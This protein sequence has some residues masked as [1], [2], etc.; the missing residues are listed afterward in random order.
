M[1]PSLQ[2]VRAWGACASIVAQACL[3]TAQADPQYFQGSAYEVIEGS[4]KWDDALLAASQR[5]YLGVQGRLATVTSAAENAF[6]AGLAPAG[7]YYFL[8]GS[9][10]A[11]EGTWT[12]VTGKEAGT[13]FWRNGAA[14]NGAYTAWRAGEPNA[15]YAA[16]DHL[17]LRGGLWQDQPGNMYLHSGYVVEYSFVPH[18]FD[19]AMSTSHAG[20]I[21]NVSAEAKL[22]QLD[23]R[24]PGDAVFDSAPGAPGTEFTA[25]SVIA[26]SVG[27]GWTLPDNLATDGQR[28]ASIKLDLDPTEALVFQVDL[29]RLSTGDGPGLAAGTVVTAHFELGDL[30]FVSTAIV[31]AGQADILGSSFAY[32]VHSEVAS[33]VPEPAS[34]ALFAGGA[35]LLALRGRRRDDADTASRA[36]S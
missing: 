29:D 35:L 21:R 12:W 13:V 34:W 36:L 14:V 1:K 9:D 22:V 25:W 31:Q 4:I 23:I 26:A 24:L 17:V 18:G 32:S 6:L 27:A 28:T 33:A 8:G 3:G 19:F 20:A 2:R 15:F 10:A 16:E 5:S 11:V 30:K 7:G